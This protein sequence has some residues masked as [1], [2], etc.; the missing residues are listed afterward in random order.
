[1]KV[2]LIILVI[3]FVVMF[4]FSWSQ[5]GNTVKDGAVSG[6]FCAIALIFAAVCVLFVLNTLKDCAN[7]PLSDEYYDSP[8]K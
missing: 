8:R 7:S 3:V 5:K 4:I 1:M 6:G 2:F